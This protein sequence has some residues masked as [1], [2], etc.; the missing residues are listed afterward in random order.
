VE[1]EIRKKRKKEKEKEHE[2]EEIRE[3]VDV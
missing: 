1:E 2:N 3:T